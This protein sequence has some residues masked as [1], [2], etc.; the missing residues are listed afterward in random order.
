M[1][2][3]AV[4]VRYN[5]PKIRSSLIRRVKRAFMEQGISMPDE[6][7]EIVFPREVPVRLL[8]EGAPSGAPPPEL[9]RPEFAGPEEPVATA[10]EGSLES[11]EDK[12]REQARTARVPEEGEDLL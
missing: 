4:G 2:R 11:E 9:R 1:V 3:G 7:R 10:A 5:G 12:I 6:A 8:Q